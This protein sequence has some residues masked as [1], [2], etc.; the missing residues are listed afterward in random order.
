[1]KEIATEASTLRELS[2]QEP[3]RRTCKGLSE[4]EDFEV[5]NNTFTVFDTVYLFAVWNPTA[6]R[7]LCQLSAENILRYIQQSPAVSYSQP[8]LVFLPV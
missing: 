4:G 1:M 2:R 8:D 3:A 5:R 7:N 6:F